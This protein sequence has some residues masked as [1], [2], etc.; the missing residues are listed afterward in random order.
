MNIFILDKDPVAAAKQMP[1]NYTGKMLLEAAQI[2]STCVRIKKGTKGE[3]MQTMQ[4]PIGKTTSVR[5]YPYVLE[6]EEPDSPMVY[7]VSHQNHPCSIWIR[8][9]KQNFTW[10]VKHAK[11]LAIEFKTRQS[12]DGSDHE[13]LAIVKLCEELM[14]DAEYPYKTLT[15]FAIASDGHPIMGDCAVETYRNHMHY[16]KCVWK[17][18]A[19]DWWSATLNE[20][21]GPKPKKKS[22]N[23]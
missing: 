23:N 1:D 18:G 22:E 4:T 10:L 2:L 21:L 19:P 9:S 8:Y 14:K 16:K 20:K 12:K 6:G 5:P 15:P 3:L 13:S 17:N 7:L 11:Q